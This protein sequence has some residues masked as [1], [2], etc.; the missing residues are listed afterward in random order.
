[1]NTN[2]GVVKTLYQATSALQLQ[3]RVLTVL[4]ACTTAV[5]AR[6]W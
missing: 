1:M 2:F 6:C 5:Y 3:A 4:L